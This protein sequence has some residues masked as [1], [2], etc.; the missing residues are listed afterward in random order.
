MSADCSVLALL[1][2]CLPKEQAQVEVFG[3][4]LI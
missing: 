2:G 3:G 4:V 1:S